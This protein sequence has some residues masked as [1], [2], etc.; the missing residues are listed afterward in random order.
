MFGNIERLNQK[1]VSLRCDDGGRWKVAPSLLE[2]VDEWQKNDGSQ[3]NSYDRNNPCP[4][5]S[6]KKY[7]KCCGKIS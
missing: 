4:C 6:G 1:S 5:G 7:K 2:K 3:N